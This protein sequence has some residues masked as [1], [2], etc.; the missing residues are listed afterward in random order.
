MSTVF[1]QS[2][3]FLPSNFTD[4]REDEP[5]LL[6]ETCLEVTDAERNKM[7]SLWRKENINS[8][9]IKIRASYP[10]EIKMILGR[11]LNHCVQMLCEDAVSASSFEAD[12]VLLQEGI[13]FLM[14]QY[15]VDDTSKFSIEVALKAAMVYSYSL[16]N[17][18]PLHERAPSQL[19]REYG[20]YPCFSE[21]LISEI[22]LSYLLAFR[23][24]MKI[25]LR[26]IP[27]NEN[28]TLII[29]I[30]ATLEGSGR[31]YSEESGDFLAFVRRLKIFEH[32][33]QNLRGA[34]NTPPKKKQKKI[35]T[36]SCGAVILR[37]TCWKHNM[38]KKHIQY[39]QSLQ[40]E[41]ETASGSQ[42]I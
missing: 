28:K 39:H 4:R 13:S 14:S 29:S 20:Q 40:R 23:Y 42:K 18:L 33:S 41:A 3:V 15:G 1:A 8:V 16:D 38:S 37:R 30:C 2:E 32:E 34:S 6:R 27:A 26:V 22:E 24:M 25:A 36:C 12:N 31:E 19:M 9:I 17:I 7:R 10:S 5:C 11:Y 21:G 35:I